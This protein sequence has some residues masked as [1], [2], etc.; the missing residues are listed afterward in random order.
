MSQEANKINVE[1]IERIEAISE[2]REEN[3]KLKQELRI[4]H[5]HNEIIKKAK[6][7]NKRMDDF[8]D[9]Q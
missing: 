3:E 4:Q 9:G 5:Q 6:E 8:L 7:R 1:L 2:L